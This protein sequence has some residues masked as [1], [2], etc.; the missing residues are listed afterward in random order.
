[1]TTAAKRQAGTMTEVRPG[2]WRLRV[3]VGKHANG[4]PRQA[5]ATFHGGPRAARIKLAEMVA[6]RGRLTAT[7]Y[8]VEGLL[9]DFI[10]H[11][12]AIGRSPTTTDKYKQIAES[13]I[14][15]ELGKVR[16][17]KLT[18]RQL[19]ALYAKLTAKGNAATTV[20]RVHALISVALH[21]AE[22]WGLI[23]RSIARQATPPPVHTIEPKAPT[24]EEVVAIIM[25][26]AADDPMFADL[27]ALAALTGA[28]RGELCGLRWADWDRG[29]GTLLIERS[30]YETGGGSWGVKAV[31]NYASRTVTLDES[32]LGAL[33]RRWEAATDLADR[34]GAEL[35][36]DG[37]IF[38]PWP[39]GIAP[40]M[41]GKVSKV[42]ATAA[43]SAGVEAHLHLLRHWAATE[44]VG[45]GVPIPT[46]AKRLGHR[47][48]SVTL[49]V[50]SHALPAQ[51]AAA[52][53]ML[54]RSLRLQGELPAGA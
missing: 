22:K 30:V 1:M 34:L 41:P 33:G 32:A 50:Y 6:A 16:L 7:S 48:S 47:D 54:G 36:D 21:Q 38:S 13:V 9:D 31:K 14:T 51:D 29:A 35:A 45:A 39:G 8:T 5:S 52:A 26:A 4:H 44:M 20:R 53:E 12:E 40:V 15:P 19:D 24:R 10:A 3:V 49:R 37:Y 27:F 46:V 18:A 11:C 17:S 25:A 2:V 28:R 23:D 42:F 43:E